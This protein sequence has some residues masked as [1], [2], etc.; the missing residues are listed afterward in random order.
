G[1]VGQRAPQQGGAFLQPAVGKR[2]HLAAHTCNPSITYL[3]EGSPKPADPGTQ[4]RR[5]QQ[6][7]PPPSPR[8][9]RILTEAGVAG[10]AGGEGSLG[11]VGGESAR[12]VERPGEWA[13]YPACR[14]PGTVTPASDDS[15]RVVQP[16]AA[17]ASGSGVPSPARISPSRG[18][19]A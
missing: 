11:G 14:P 16:P 17:A 1:R 8:A 19:A 10:L 5:A 3:A 9:R 7:R 6:P 4:A 15:G 13:L 2:D 12:S 18:L